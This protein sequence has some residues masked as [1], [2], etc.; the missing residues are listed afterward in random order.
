MVGH[1]VKTV[2]NPPS[3]HR[4]KNEVLHYFTLSISSVNVTSCTGNC[5]FGHIYWRNPYWKYSFLSNVLLSS[6]PDCSPASIWWATACRDY[7][8]PWP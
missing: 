5:E 4:I 1:Y 3:F 8:L 7:T 6:C 2:G